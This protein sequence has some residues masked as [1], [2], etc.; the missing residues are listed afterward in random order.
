MSKLSLAHFGARKQVIGKVRNVVLESWRSSLTHGF[1]GSVTF[2]MT[3]F[4]SDVEKLG[5]IK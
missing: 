4:H 3:A 2:K 5:H 1:D